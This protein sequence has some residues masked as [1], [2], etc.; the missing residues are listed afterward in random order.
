MSLSSRPESIWF[1]PYTSSYKNFKEK[2]FKIFVEL[3]DKPYFYDTK[4]RTKFPFHWTQSPTWYISWPRSSM[5]PWDK[6]FLCVLDQLPNKLPTQ[7][8]VALYESSKRW[9]NFTGMWTSYAYNCIHYFDEVFNSFLFCR[10]HVTCRS[11]VG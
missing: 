2:Y 3:D 9:T 5:T 8:L 6:E 4:G 10:H 11:R 7:E 1:A